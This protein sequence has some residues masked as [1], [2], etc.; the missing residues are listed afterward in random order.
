MSRAGWLSAIAFYLGLSC[1]PSLIEASSPLRQIGRSCGYVLAQITKFKVLRN[2]RALHRERHDPKR[3]K[4]LWQ[5]LAEIENTM[6]LADNHQPPFQ[7]ALY[8]L[9]GALILRDE[10]EWLQELL[11]HKIERASRQSIDDFSI[12]ETID[13]LTRSNNPQFAPLILDSL[14]KAQR[15][16]ALSHATKDLEIVFLKAIDRQLEILTSEISN[17]H[18]IYWRDDVFPYGPIALDAF[19]SLALFSLE[20]S[21]D[22]LSAILQHPLAIQ[23]GF[24]TSMVSDLE[25]ETS[26]ERQTM[27]QSLLTSMWQLLEERKQDHVW[28]KQNFERIHLAYLE[29]RSQHHSSNF[30]EVANLDS[31]EMTWLKRLCDILY[32]GS[33]KSLSKHFRRAT[34]KDLESLTR[35]RLLK[36]EELINARGEITGSLFYISLSREMIARRLKRLGG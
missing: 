31:V 36:F 10:I 35:W 15:L 18:V 25:T 28:A 22:L 23:A 27:A 11:I 33:L 16:S 17:A 26:V 8:E 4:Q 2:I 6:Q 9:R 24:P 13:D 12:H 5:K 34:D 21:R 20:E 7:N 3:Q 1:F 29:A 32:Q 14:I 19:R 30:S